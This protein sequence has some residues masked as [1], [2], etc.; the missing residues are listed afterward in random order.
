MSFNLTFMGEFIITVLE[1]SF[2]TLSIKERV[3]V[4]PLY[5]ILVSV[6]AVFSNTN[7][8]AKSWGRLSQIHLLESTSG[9]RYI[10]FLH[11]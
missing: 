3:K 4:L 5:E 11:S 10:S 1:P 2:N 6:T 8:R 9:N 7:D